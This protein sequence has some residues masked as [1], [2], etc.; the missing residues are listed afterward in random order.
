[1][2]QLCDQCDL[3]EARPNSHWDSVMEGGEVTRHP[4]GRKHQAWECPECGQAWRSI[5]Y[6][7][8]RVEWSKVDATG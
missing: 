1:M 5:N 3:I 2:S 4:I 6:N 7:D 8:V